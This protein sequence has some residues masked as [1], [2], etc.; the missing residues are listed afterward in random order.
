MLSSILMGYHTAKHGSIGLSP[1]AVMFGREP[2]RPVDIE[3][4]IVQPEAPTTDCSDAQRERVFQLMSQSRDIIKGVVKENIG[5]AQE[6]QKK[7][8][9]NRHQKRLNYLNDVLVSHA[10]DH[11]YHLVTGCT[12]TEAEAACSQL[13]KS[14][15]K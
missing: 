9:D 10:V 8:L 13:R 14:L 2:L 1:F 15:P 6:R 7:N 12:E 5:K 3:D 4:N 11:L